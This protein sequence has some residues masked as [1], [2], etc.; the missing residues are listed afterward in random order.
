MVSC[1]YRWKG[2][3]SSTLPQRPRRSCRW[4]N[5]SLTSTDNA[6][7][8][9]TTPTLVLCD[10]NT[11]YSLGLMVP[12]KGPVPRA[13]RGVWV[14]LQELEYTRMILKSDGEPSIT[15]LVT[16]VQKEW[17]GDSKK[18]S[19][20][21]DSPPTCPVDDHAPNGAAEAMVHSLEGLTRISKVVLEE[22]LGVSIS[23]SSPILPWLV[24]RQSFI[25]NKF[26]RAAEHLLKSW[27]WASARVCYSIWA[28]LFLQKI[29]E[30]KRENWVHRGIWVFG[31]DGR[32]RQM[33]ILSAHELVCSGPGQW[34]DVQRQSNATE[35]CMKRWSW[36][37]SKRGGPAWLSLSMT[38]REHYSHV[39]ASSFQHDLF[40]QTR[41]YVRASSAYTRRACAILIANALCRRITLQYKYKT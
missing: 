36:C 29:L 18:F 14:F 16:A 4:T 6:P 37:L 38:F 19:N 27:P 10:G 23:S 3:R 31:W 40:H 34:N 22:S 41:D 32:R 30:P 2:P 8:E 24:R 26:V 12:R 9:G 33:N 7:G 39:V 17:A 5:F 1:M 15:S 25:R 28:R 20:T 11:T 35:G 13:V 21:V